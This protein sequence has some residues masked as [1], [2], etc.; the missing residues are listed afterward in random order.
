MQ[1]RPTSRTD[2]PAVITSLPH[3]FFTLPF[4]SYAARVA[5]ICDD[6]GRGPAPALCRARRTDDANHPRGG[7]ASHPGFGF[8]IFSRSRKKSSTNEIVA[9]SSNKFTRELGV[10]CTAWS[11]IHV[12]SR[13][14]PTIT[15]M[16]LPITPGTGVRTIR[17]SQ[18]ILKVGGF[19]LSPVQKKFS[20]VPRF[21]AT[22]AWLGIIRRVTLG[23]TRRV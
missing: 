7:I 13:I 2:P 18:I 8:R 5:F 14:I 17:S 23:E 1:S 4:E 21:A 6:V 15:S 19:R 16:E 22:A 10:R 9:N 3:C 12:N 11:K 20:V